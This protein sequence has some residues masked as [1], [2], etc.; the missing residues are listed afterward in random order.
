[1]ICSADI[2]YCSSNAW[3]QI[4]EVDLGMAADV[5]TLQRLPKIIGSH[6]LVKELSYTGRKM[7]A[8]EALQC[9]FVSRV[10]DDEKRY[11]FFI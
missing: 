10:L 5:G 11:I 2:R 7:L 3:F 6:S 4:K 1:M 9:G 8:P